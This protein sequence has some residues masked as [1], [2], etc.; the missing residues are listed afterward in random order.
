MP[1]YEIDDPRWELCDEDKCEAEGCDEFADCVVE[2]EGER[3]TFCDVHGGKV[4]F[5]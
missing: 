2:V 3:K 4:M 5:G 1:I